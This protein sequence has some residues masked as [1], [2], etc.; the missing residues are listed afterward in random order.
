MERAPQA[1]LQRSHGRHPDLYSPGPGA[2]YSPGSTIRLSNSILFRTVF[3]CRDFRS[4]KFI[5][6]FRFLQ[7]PALPVTRRMCESSLATIWWNE[8][9][10]RLFMRYPKKLVGW[11]E[12][13]DESSHQ[14]FICMLC[15]YTHFL[16]SIV[17]IDPFRSI[18]CIASIQTLFCRANI[19][20]VIYLFVIDLSSESCLS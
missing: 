18:D 16:R 5:T 3:C 10:S 14:V 12:L 7:T 9:S 19:T 1:L 8:N 13:Y 6:H 11:G 4:H 2:V 17:T 15:L 20:V